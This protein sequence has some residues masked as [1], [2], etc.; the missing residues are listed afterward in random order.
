MRGQQW[1]CSVEC[2]ISRKG[3][4]TNQSS[5]SQQCLQGREAGPWVSWAGLWMQHVTPR[6]LPTYQLLLLQPHPGCLCPSPGTVSPRL[7]QRK[8]MPAPR[9]GSLCA[10]E[11][12]LCAPPGQCPALA[13]TRPGALYVPCPWGCMG[14]QEATRTLDP[15]ELHGQISPWRTHGATSLCSSSHQ[16]D[17][18]LAAP[19]THRP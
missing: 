3:R 19:A 17:P 2:G 1:Q 7:S 15:S 11:V 13:S 18:A 4:P 8:P 5:V 14:A 10:E 6:V 9:P 12:V 16:P